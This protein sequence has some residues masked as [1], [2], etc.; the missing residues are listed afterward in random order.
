MKLTRKKLRQL[1]LKEFKDATSGANF[2]IRGG[3]FNLPPDE[4]DDGGGPGKPL[5]P[6]ENFNTQAWKNSYDI[7]VNIF[8]QAY[9]VTGDVYQFLED[10]LD[11]NNEK[12]FSH[13]QMKEALDAIYYRD[14][15]I[16]LQEDL[17]T[18]MC[19]TIKYYEK[20]YKEREDK[21]MLVKNKTYQKERS[22]FLQMTNPQTL[23]DMITNY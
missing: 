15:L 6:C 21:I 18:E 3:G 20:Q 19:K 17:A 1:I 22:I 14:A 16:N 10:S 4:P 7:I 8:E 11:D 12:L 9:N 13:S 2:N 23:F 5:T